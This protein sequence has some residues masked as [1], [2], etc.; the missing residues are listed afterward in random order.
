MIEKGKDPVIGKLQLIQLI[1]ADLQIIMRICINNRI[2]KKKKQIPEYQKQTTD[3]E[4]T[5]QQKMLCLKRESSMTIAHY[6][7]NAQYTI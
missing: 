2:R 6:Y 5:I 1:K 7:I 4:L 3:Q